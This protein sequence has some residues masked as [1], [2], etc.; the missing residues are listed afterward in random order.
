[1]LPDEPETGHTKN[2]NTILRGRY[3]NSSM[4]E[5]ESES[6]RSGSALSKNSKGAIGRK[7]TS[8]FCRY[9]RALPVICSS[10]P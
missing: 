10:Q 6:A 8:V 4:S 5:N 2:R 9:L 7:K 1:M 3:R